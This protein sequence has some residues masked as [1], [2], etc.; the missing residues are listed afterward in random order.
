MKKLIFLLILSIMGCSKSH[1]SYT[2]TNYIQAHHTDFDYSLG[3]NVVVNNVYCR[4]GEG[5]SMNPTFFEDN[6]VCMK[7]YKNETLKQGNIIHYYNNGDKL[8]RIAAVEDSQLL[9]AG[10]NSYEEIINKSQVKGILVLVLY[11]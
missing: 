4:R 10:D 9:V 3:N 1:Y 2:K 5:S 7:E 6:I 11:K 8:H